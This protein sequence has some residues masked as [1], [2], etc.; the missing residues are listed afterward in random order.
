MLLDGID[1]TFERFLKRVEVE[2]R[3]AVRYEFGGEPLAFHAKGKV[4]DLLWP[5]ERKSTAA[6]GGDAGTRAFTPAGVPPCDVCGGER[7][8]E[9][10]LMPNL[11]NLLKTDEI[12]NADGAIAPD[13]SY[14][15]TG[16]GESEGEEA[17]RKA[18]I[19]QA[20]GRRLPN[21]TATT[22][23]PTPLMANPPSM[24]GQAR[25]E[26]RIHLHLRQRLLPN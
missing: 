9:A 7:V 10:Q 13:T 4:Y 14:S 26:Y 21:P 15:L 5:G 3:Q 19:E 16:K 1:D 8:F 2:P 20:L 24:Q 23:T 6:K 22:R 17:K 25:L 11:I 12:Q 18:A